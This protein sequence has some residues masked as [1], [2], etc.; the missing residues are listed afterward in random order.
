MHDRA[1]PVLAEQAG[2]QGLVLDVAADKD[3]S[4]GHRPLEAGGKV[5]DY[6]F[7]SAGVDQ[8]EHGM[9]ADIAGAARHQ[10]G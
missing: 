2:E 3:G 8:G 7:L 10:H 4:G 6:Y 9:A 1:D 5:V